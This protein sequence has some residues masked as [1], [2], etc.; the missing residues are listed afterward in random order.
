MGAPRHGTVH[1]VGNASV[2]LTLPVARLPLPGETLIATG[3]A[4]RAAGGKGLNQA[5]MAAR[6]GARVRFLAPVGAERAEITAALAEEGLAEVRL[7]DKPV[8]TDMS[9]LLVAA[10]GENAIVSTGACAEALGPGEARDFLAPAG[11]GDLVLLQGNLSRDATEAAMAAAGGALVVLNL[12]PVRWGLP[13]LPAGAVLVVNEVEAG[14]IAGGG[15]PEEA[16]LRLA[17]GGT[18]TI[19]TLGGEGAIW[20]A[21]GNL[22]R[23][24]APAALVVDTTGAGDVFCGVLAAALARRAEM[25][26][27]ILLAQ[28]LAAVSV[29]REGCLVSFPSRDECA[30]AVSG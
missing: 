6:A 4:R 27:A 23:L 16:G 11:P 14:Q 17:A 9:V 22:M 1:V 7:A 2:D 28:R 29:G 12:A 18:G 13:E 20:C 24:K 26:E 30:C 21:G 25:E 19:V 10:S 3:P 8:P 5:V 15:G